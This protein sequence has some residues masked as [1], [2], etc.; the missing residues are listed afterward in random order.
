TTVAGTGEEGF[1][2]DGGLATEAK[3]YGPNGIVVDQ[4]GNLFIADTNNNR[5]RKVNTNGIITTVV[6]SGDFGYGGDQ[7]PAINAKLRSPAGITIDQEN[8]LLIADGNNHCIRK[9]GPPSTFLSAQ[10][11]GDIPFADKNGLGYIMDSTSRHKK[12]INLDTG[13]TLYTFE[14]ETF[15]DKKYLISI[16][17]QFD[18]Q[19][20]INRDI[21]GTPTSI[22]SPD[23]LET[24]LTID[25]NN[26][27]TSITNP[28][29][30]IYNFTYS[31]GG[32][33]QQK[34]EPNTNTYN[35]L[36]DQGGRVTD[37]L[38]EENGH[39]QFQ[40]IIDNDGTRH[41]YITTAGNN[42]TSHED[43]V[44]STNKYT[45]KTITPSGDE[46]NYTRS[47]DR[48]SAQTT[49]LCGNSF[50]YKYD[51]DP[52]YKYDF[53]KEI[54]KSTPSGLAKIIQNTRSYVDTNSDEI[55]DLIT[56]NLSINNKTISIVRNTLSSTKTIT[57]PEGRQATLTYDP[58]TLVINTFSI[59][60][61]NQTDYL[62]NTTGRIESITTGTR[63]VSYT[64]D[65]NGYFDSVTNPENHTT[66]YVNDKAG[67]VTSV[68]RSD[69]STLEFTY[70]KNGNMTVLTNPDTIDHI[71]GYN[72]VSLWNN[73]ITPLSGSYSYTYDKDRRLIQK[74]F[75]SGKA[76]YFDY[77]DPDNLSDKSRLWTVTT[78]EGA[79]NLT[80]SCST[81]IESIAK[82]TE[83]INYTYDGSL[84]TSESFS[85]LI[86]QTLTL[87]YNNDFNVETFTYAGD[88]VSYAYDN[89]GLLTRSRDYTI[90][91]NAQNGLPESVTDN[92]LTLNRTFNAYG[93]LSQKSI[94]VNA[95]NLFELNLAT[96]NNGRVTTKTETVEGTNSSYAY[97]YDQLGRL[98]TVTK[99]AALIEEYRYDL[100]GTRNYEMNTLRG[101]TGRTFTYSDEDHLL[102]AGSNTYQYDLD[103]FLTSKT[104]GSDNTTYTYSSRGE[105]LNV[106]LPDS[107]YIEYVHDPT[108]RRIAKKIDG[109]IAEKYLWAGKTTLLA[110]FDG[111]DNLTAR[112]EYAD[113]RMPV[114]MVKQ[115]IKYY[116]IYDQVGSLRVVSDNAGN[117]VKQIDY[118]SFGN[119]I[120]D[121][122]PT[123]T[124]P[125]GFA[126]GLHDIDTGLVRF[127]Y[128]DY[129]TDIG[130]W[131][132]KDP[133]LFA[134]GDSDLFGYCL[135]DPV[136]FLDPDG[137]F[138]QIA[139]GVFAGA[140]GGFLSGVQSGNIGNALLAG[141]AGGLVGGVV[142]AILPTA[143][144]AVGGMV[145]G[146]VSGALGGAF[147]G[148]TGKKLN[149]PC[150]SLADVGMAAVKGGGIG[151]VTG[152]IG[153]GL[154]GAAASIGATGIGVDIGIAN[155]TAPIGWG[156]SLDW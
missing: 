100:K 119:I 94:N 127:G 81:K 5:I 123:F 41:N 101:I 2:G 20:T 118:D 4:Q 9:I 71:F 53:V 153:G 98:L 37:F 95:N 86:N 108:G 156:M 51:V 78:P 49:S 84:I 142:G 150:A 141:V 90:S 3:L 38:N 67:R 87:T 66:S 33:L 139:I 106:T 11:P 75:P 126:G 148:A 91:R 42:Q 24:L 121:T 143:S 21:D 104:I 113:G 109:V 18:N 36:F 154:S 73:Y 83:Y 64:Y 92:T 88:T 70:D 45:S 151:A 124:I 1:S 102:T 117:I 65:Y 82:G 52:E 35:Y 103:G 114:S 69:G 147:G 152:T 149:D 120:T 80:Y 145:G 57:S 128:R 125:F 22:V 138:A 46:I 130:R 144:G 47:S 155:I 58:D 12:T 26:H 39:D 19:T 76:I 54:I 17:D 132:A 79:I 55:P 140:Y 28:D 59:P 44:F 116:L 10:S 99:D 56:K 68:H 89:D 122:D 110:I 129:D 6:G 107:R 111:S 30:G 43:F 7:G 60:G 62:Y 34:N 77:S 16:T 135:S 131:T 29:N 48:L 8:N 13:K 134:G 31:S 105:L 32:L 115:G 50:D 97:T 63:T 93:E 85:G 133:I 96:D 61:L 136:N 74:D 27:L 137:Q 23:G 112:F 14:Y 72:K 15:N 25:T 40:R 146:F